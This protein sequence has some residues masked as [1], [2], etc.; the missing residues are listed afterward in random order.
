MT[1][2]LTLNLG[3]SSSFNVE[4]F[5]DVCGYNR[6]V[7]YAILLIEI[8]SFSIDFWWNF[9]SLDGSS[10]HLS[11]HFIPS[12]D[13]FFSSL[14]VDLKVHGALRNIKL[15][16]VHTGTYWVHCSQL[17]SSL[18]RVL[19]NKPSGPFCNVVNYP[20][21]LQEKKPSSGPALIDRIKK[22]RPILYFIF[23]V[24]FY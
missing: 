5:L 21:S 8:G 2:T 12:L 10:L 19:M 17:L 13:H 4:S 24:A 18:K 14:F 16:T 15:F 9:P 1:G 6:R 7:S 11:A 20:F 23:S 22:K 3:L